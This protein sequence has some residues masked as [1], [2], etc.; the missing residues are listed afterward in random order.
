[1]RRARV[2]EHEP[3]LQ[4]LHIDIDGN[5]LDSIGPQLNCGD[6]AMVR[7]P[8]VLHPGRHIDHL[9]FDVHRNGHEG[10]GIEH[11]SGPSRKRATDG[12]VE[13]RRSPDAGTLGG[14]PAGAKRQILGLKE[15]REPAKKRKLAHIAQ[16]LPGRSLDG[17]SGIDRLELEPAVRPG[18]ISACARRLMAALSVC[19]SSWNRYMGQI[20]R[21][22]PARS[23]LVGAELVICFMFVRA[24]VERVRERCGE[25]DR[26]SSR[27]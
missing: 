24:A 8:V 18:V 13:R 12:D 4:L 26:R 25:R 7:G 23:I 27:E 11:R 5:A 20:S 9:R 2:N 17:D 19:A 15:R 3:P 22:P 14:F 10:L 16:L 1:M 6:A 21:V